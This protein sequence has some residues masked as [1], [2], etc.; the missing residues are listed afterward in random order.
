MHLLRIKQHLAHGKR[1][2]QIEQ[3][4]LDGGLEVERV[5]GRRL[6][7]AMPNQPHPLGVGVR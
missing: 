7:D 6:E 5:V 4:R 2:L 3:R 1:R